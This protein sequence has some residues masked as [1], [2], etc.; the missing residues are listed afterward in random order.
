M[1]CFDLAT[2][3][4]DIRVTEVIREDE[5]DVGL[6]CVERAAQGKEKEASHAKENARR[7]DFSLGA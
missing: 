1:R 3:K 5:D 4:A 7:I 6:R 2:M